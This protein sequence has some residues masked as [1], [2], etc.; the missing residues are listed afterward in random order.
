M[1]ITTDEAA[2]MYARYCRARYGARAPKI[3]E[4]KA[5]ELRASGDIEGERV[6]SKVKTQIEQQTASDVAAL[7]P[8]LH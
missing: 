6:W 3:A 7:E 2:E 4:R 5:A 8:A 1:W